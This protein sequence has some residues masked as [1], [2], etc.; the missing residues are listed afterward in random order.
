ME[1]NGSPF[2]TQNAFS[3]LLFFLLVS[4]LQQHLR[5]RVL[6]PFSVT[7]PFRRLLTESYRNGVEWRA[8]NCWTGINLTG[9]FIGAWTKKKTLVGK[10]KE[11]QEVETNNRDSGDA[12]RRVKWE[13][14]FNFF[15]CFFWWSAGTGIIKKQPVLYQHGCYK[16]VKGIGLYYTFVIVYSLYCFE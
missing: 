5:W 8:R 14:F 2:C 12:W 15:F 3:F 9:R 6:S 16:G 13:F 10:Q 1:V 4:P 7:L 11:K